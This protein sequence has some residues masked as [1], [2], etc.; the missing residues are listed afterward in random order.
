[1]QATSATASPYPPPPQG[2]MPAGSHSY[3]PNHSAGASSPRSSAEPYD[4]GAAID[5]ALEGAGTPQ[6]QNNNNNNN[7]YEGAQEFKQSLD[8][9]SPYPPNASGQNHR[10]KAPC[11]PTCRILSTKYYTL[12]TLSFQRSGRRSMTSWRLTAFLL[13]HLHR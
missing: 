7:S 9:A 1:M 13:L 2:Y 3:A 8:N 11:S 12:L 5:P 6:L 4:Y 10:G